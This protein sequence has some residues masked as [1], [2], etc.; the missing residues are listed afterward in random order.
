MIIKVGYKVKIPSIFIHYSDGEKLVD[1]LARTD[2]KI[3]L[4]I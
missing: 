2:K 1:L 4:K 3:I